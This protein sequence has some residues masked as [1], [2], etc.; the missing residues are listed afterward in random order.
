M[1]SRI[2]AVFVALTFALS[3]PAL[4]R[5]EKSQG[6]APHKSVHATSS[7]TDP[8]E[9]P[10]EPPAADPAAATE[11][12]PSPEDPAGDPAPT[13]LQA[14]P[15]P[16]C[17]DEVDTA[18]RF[19]ITVD[20]DARLAEGFYA[21][22]QT[23]PVGMVVFSHGYGHSSYS[24]QEHAARVAQ[25]LN[26]VAIA[27]DGRDLAILDTFKRPGIPNAAGWPVKS[28]AEDGIAAAQAFEAACASIDTIVNYGVSMGGNTSGIMAASGA[29]RADGATPLFDWWVDVEGVN[30][31][32]ETYME[33]RGADPGAA[34]AIEAET[35]GP[36]EEAQDAYIQRTN[37]LR[38][39]DMKDAGLKGVVLVHGVDDGL[40]PHNQGHE[41][42]DA[43]T[44]VGIPAQFFV[45][46]LKSDESERETSL[47]GHALGLVDPEYRSPA[48]GHAS[49]LST[50]HIVGVTG[51]ERLTAIFNGA[52]P[53]CTRIAVVDGQVGS[54]P[55]VDC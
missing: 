51:F 6:K 24:W 18:V 1:R 49:E 10:T 47:T 8:A 3:L 53:A 32:I 37:V 2:F 31:L 5:P 38:V 17:T 33:A 41:M 16:P 34:G 36:I 39:Q 9:Q 20:D 15:W 22:P 19:G 21:V 43:L 12:E 4:A 52:P 42:F 55:L 35:G 25:E 14:T 27:M 26:V 11:P 29:K 45:V 23:D 7:P 50:T 46:T 44:A 30:N 48:A 54:T 40:V 13:A 28:A